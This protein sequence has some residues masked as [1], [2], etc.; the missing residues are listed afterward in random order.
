MILQITLSQNM[1]LSIKCLEE[2]LK[3]GCSWSGLL[4]WTTDIK[5]PNPKVQVKQG[6]DIHGNEH[7][8]IL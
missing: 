1:Y 6:S 8:F 7:S 2:P 3:G 4:K 5:L